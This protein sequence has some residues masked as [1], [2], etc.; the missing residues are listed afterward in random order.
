MSFPAAV[1]EDLRGSPA[2]VILTVNAL[3]GE[4]AMKTEEK[5]EY[6]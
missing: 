2:R 1:I 3:F 6:F 4:N 5:F